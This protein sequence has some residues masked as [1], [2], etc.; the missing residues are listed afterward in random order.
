MNQKIGKTTFILQ[1]LMIGLVA[2][3]I[4]IALSLLL[5]TFHFIPFHFFTSLST[6]FVTNNSIAKVILYGIVAIFVTMV[7]MLFALIYA[8]LLRKQLHWKY[9]AFYGVLLWLIFYVI[10]PYVLHKKITLLHYESNVSITMF[11]LFLL[12]GVFVGYSIS[13]HCHRV[14]RSKV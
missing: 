13:F 4:S 11:C 7:S 10:A 5:H 8:L 2:S 6:F 12:Y 9:G 1:A 3:M 14:I